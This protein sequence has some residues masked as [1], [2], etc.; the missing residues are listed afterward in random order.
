[1]RNAVGGVLGSIFVG[2]CLLHV[3]WAL[4]GRLGRGAAV[5]S[6]AGKPLFTPSPLGTLLVAAGLLIAALV[7]AGTVGWLGKAVPTRVFR[8]LAHAISVV[9]IVRAIGDFRY[10]GFFRGASDSVFAYWDLRLY[11][12][13]CLFIGAAV[14]VLVWSRK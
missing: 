9:F 3:Y 2:L 8:L 14:F 6:V 5:P 10:V 12:P 11:S 4:G 1:V 13:L 7:I